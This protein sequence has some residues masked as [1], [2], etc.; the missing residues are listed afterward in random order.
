MREFVVGALNA[1][2]G[3]EAVD[4]ELVDAAAGGSFV[5]LSGMVLDGSQDSIESPVTI[6][7]ADDPDVDGVVNEV[8]ESLV[9]FLEFY[10]LKM[11]CLR[12]YRVS[13]SATRRS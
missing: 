9:D 5:T 3:L 4:P 11:P 8:P 6:D 2:M 12:S 10:L 1:E 13:T 7:D